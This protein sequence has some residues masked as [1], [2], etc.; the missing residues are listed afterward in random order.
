MQHHLL[1]VGAGSIG[2]RHLRCFQATTRCQVSFVEVREELRHTIAERYQVRGYTSLDAALDANDSLTAA[3]VATPADHHVDIA[4][5]LADRGLHLLIEKPLS[6]SLAGVDRLAEVI[7]HKSL[8]AAVAYV[9]RCYPALAEMQSAIASGRFG[10]PLEIVAVSGQ[11]FATYRPAYR[12]TY[13]AQHATGGGAIQDALTHMLNAGQWLVGPVDRVVA[14][15]QHQQLDGVEVEDTAHLLTRHGNV[16]GS[17]SLNQYQAPNEMVIK[18]VCTAGTVQFESHASRWRWMTTPDV[19]WHD[20]P[21]QP[22]TRDAPFMSQAHRFLDVIEG[23][24][25]PLCSLDEGVQS[26]RVNL[27]ALESIRSQSWQ[28]IQSSE[29]ASTLER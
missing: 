24:A 9:C 10:R 15:A 7:A 14:D 27:A 29:S 11:N 6:T 12:Q 18:V 2:E 1:I 17:F 19:P 21:H 25:T 3:V 22:L 16:L 23:K 13:Y 5:R 8:H 28:T 26:L 4:I 20:E